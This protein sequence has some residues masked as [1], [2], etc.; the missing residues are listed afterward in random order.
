MDKLEINMQIDLNDV[1]TY[2][3]ET[4]ADILKE[5]I[6]FAIRDELRKTFKGNLPKKLREK[7]KLLA[8]EVIRENK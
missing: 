1:Y 2:G 7:I 3:D 4:V 5:E 6:K 8:E